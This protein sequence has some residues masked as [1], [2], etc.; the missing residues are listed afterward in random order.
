MATEANA[1]DTMRPEQAP[2]AAEFD[3]FACSYDALH[4]ENTRASGWSTEHFAEYKIREVARRVRRCGWEGSAIR[5]LNF[6]CGIGNSEGFLRRYLPRA[7]IHGIDL[8]C[9]SIDLARERHRGLA[10]VHF[11][12]FDGCHLPFAP[13][14]DLIFVA[15][16]LHHVPRAEHPATLALL[17]RAL[18]PC[19]LL[20]IFEHNPLNPVTARAVHECPFDRGAVMLPP[21]YSRR[22][23]RRAG[24]RVLAQRFTL[25]FPRALAPLA[26][27]ERYLGWLPLGAQYYLMGGRGRG[28]KLE[29]GR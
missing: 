9:R 15:N 4:A 20:F 24:L 25:F 11:A 1:G 26:P 14:F 16:V 6:G 13:P 23:V 10:G 3:R 17:R 28:G 2:V 12:P 5:V 21:L 18:D 29:V 22:A 19:G 8:S 27:L 7:E